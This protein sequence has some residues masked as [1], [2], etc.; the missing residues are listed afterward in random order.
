[1]ATESWKITTSR[2]ANGDLPKVNDRIEVDGIPADV[3]QVH[4]FHGIQYQ[5]LI[6]G[7]VVDGK[8]QFITDW[9]PWEI[10]LDLR[11]VEPTDEVINL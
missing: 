8:Q 3:I 10:V 1:M 2:N 6:P 7:L 11:K 4:T 5:I 9:I